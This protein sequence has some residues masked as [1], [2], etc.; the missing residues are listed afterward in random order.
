MPARPWRTTKRQD[1]HRVVRMF[2]PVTHETA[3]ALRAD[4]CHPISA[5]TADGAA[6]ELLIDLHCCTNIDTHGLLVLD[7]AQQAARARG[8]DLHLIRVPPLVQR[9][10][11]QHSLDHLIQPDTDSARPADSTP[12]ARP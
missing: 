8:G 5:C 2:G 3:A 1:Q 10:I 11:R 7:V 6:V 12:T 4:L 9:V